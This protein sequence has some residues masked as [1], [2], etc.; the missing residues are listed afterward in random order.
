MKLLCV[1]VEGTLSGTFAT[2]N[3]FF[4]DGRSSCSDRVAEVY[5]VC[6]SC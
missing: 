3:D 4:L 2:R 1:Q 5:L 6:S